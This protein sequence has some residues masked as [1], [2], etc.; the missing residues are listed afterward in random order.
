M[1]LLEHVS[2]VPS[3]VQSEAAERELTPSIPAPGKTPVTSTRL[4]S[5]GW[6]APVPTLSSPAVIGDTATL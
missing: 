2:R 6:L 4:L 3:R 1:Q 5:V